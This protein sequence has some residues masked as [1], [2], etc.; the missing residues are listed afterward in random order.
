[1]EST[2]VTIIEITANLLLDFFI[3]TFAQALA[4]G[5]GS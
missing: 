5:F 2:V 1:V 3:L 4:S